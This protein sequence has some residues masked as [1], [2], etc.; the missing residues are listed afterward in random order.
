MADSLAK[1]DKITSIILENPYYGR[2]K[3]K[4]QKLEE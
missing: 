4:D 2:R 3:P 1:K